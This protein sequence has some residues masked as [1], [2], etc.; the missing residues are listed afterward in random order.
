MISYC[1]YI[2]FEDKNL[3]MIFDALNNKRS[4]IYIFDLVW[5]L[6]KN[7]FLIANIYRVILYKFRYLLAI[8][9]FIN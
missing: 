3:F 9:F 7:L 6:D 2:I 5:F 4:L 8:I 1:Y